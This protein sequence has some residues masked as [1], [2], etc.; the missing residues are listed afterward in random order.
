MSSKQIAHIEL[1]TGHEIF[2][3][4]EDG[5]FR[6]MESFDS[7]VGTSRCVLCEETKTR[8]E[9]LKHLCWWLDYLIKGQVSIKFEKDSNVDGGC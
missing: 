2:L 4:E 9:G 5:C 8:I 6:V 7:L 3:I 1:K